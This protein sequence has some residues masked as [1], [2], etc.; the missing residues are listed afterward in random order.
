[1]MT[2]WHYEYKEL[3]FRPQGIT[4]GCDKYKEKYIKSTMGASKNE[5]HKVASNKCFKILLE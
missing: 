3:S 4:I 2:Q 5:K 1:M